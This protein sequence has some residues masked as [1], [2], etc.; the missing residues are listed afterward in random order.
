LTPLHEI[1]TTTLK[2]LELEYN[3]EGNLDELCEAHNDLIK[4]II[5]KE[6]ELITSHREHIDKVVDVIKSDMALLQI[7]DQPNSDIEQ[8]VKDLDRMLIDK[9]EMIGKIRLQLV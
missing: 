2:E 3:D 5:E 9:V 1:P 8:Y 4:V 6:E 7:V